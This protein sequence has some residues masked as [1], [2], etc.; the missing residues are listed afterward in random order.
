MMLYRMCS[1]FHCLPGPGGLFD[2]DSYVVYGLQ[3][4]S[5]AVAEREKKDSAPKSPNFTGG[6]SIS[7]R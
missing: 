3:A 4:I 5:M 1:E 2:Q 6:P 7:R